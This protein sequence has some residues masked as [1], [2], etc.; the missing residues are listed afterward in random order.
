MTLRI[1][2]KTYAEWHMYIAYRH[3]TFF[4]VI[5]DAATQA[6]GICDYTWASLC[7]ELSNPSILP[8]KLQS[9]PDYITAYDALS[10]IV[11]LLKK[12]FDKTSKYIMEILNRRP[13]LKY[14]NRKIA[15]MWSVNCYKYGYLNSG[16]GYRWA[17]HLIKTHYAWEL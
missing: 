15:I 9:L 11:S 12:F 2:K 5:E 1:T 14:S 6:L 7:N 17:W 16:T 10:L 8:D 3:R 13:N 4:D